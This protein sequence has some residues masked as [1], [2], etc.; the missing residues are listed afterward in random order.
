MSHRA[1]LVIDHLLLGTLLILRLFCIVNRLLNPLLK[2]KNL[3]INKVLVY[4]HLL[5]EISH[6]SFVDQLENPRARIFNSLYALLFE[7]ENFQTNLGFETSVRSVVN[8]LS[9]KMEHF[10]FGFCEF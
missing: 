3:V 2:I 10:G 8:G 6:L 5:L 9:L 4:F 1:I 7:I